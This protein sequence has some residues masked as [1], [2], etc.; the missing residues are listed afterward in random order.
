MMH[1]MFGQ[2]IDR[3]HRSK[4][5]FTQC[6]SHAHTHARTNE[7]SLRSGGL[8]LRSFRV[9]EWE[10]SENVKRRGAEMVEMLMVQLQMRDCEVQR[11]G[12]GRVG[13]G[14]GWDGDKEGA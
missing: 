13:R 2:V 4:I 5:A 11:R 9:S 8:A 12:K 14:M 6:F 7:D 10:C 3:S 1:I